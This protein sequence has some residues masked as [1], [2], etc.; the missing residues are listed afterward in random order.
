VGRRLVVQGLGAGLTLC[1]AG[2]D[3]EALPVLAE[4]LP[5]ARDLGMQDEVLVMLE[6]VARVLRERGAVEGD[7][8]LLIADREQR[9]RGWE[10]GPTLGRPSRRSVADLADQIGD[11]FRDLAS[12]AA[13]MDV[14]EAIGMVERLAAAARSG[15]QPSSI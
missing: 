6:A 14:D 3:D 13:E 12:A 5:L 11:D 2:R 15:P 4:T 10:G 1:A 8:L 9:A 7:L